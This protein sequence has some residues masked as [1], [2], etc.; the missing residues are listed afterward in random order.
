MYKHPK[1]SIHSNKRKLGLNTCLNFPFRILKEGIQHV[2]AYNGKPLLLVQYRCYSIEKE[3][4]SL[5]RELLRIERKYS[6]SAY[7][8]NN[9]SDSTW[10][11]LL[12]DFE[13]IRN[14]KGIGPQ[15]MYSF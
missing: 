5:I 14:N 9:E 7:I 4:E 1:C 10:G 13:L 2:E 12:K 8:V 11:V 15:R 6:I 3:W